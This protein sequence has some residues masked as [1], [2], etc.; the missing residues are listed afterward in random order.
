MSAVIQRVAAP[1]KPLAPKV[2]HEKEVCQEPCVSAVPVAKQMDLNHSMV[3]S[4]CQFLGFVRPV[5][6]PELRVVQYNS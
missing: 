2:L 1:S 3:Q 5:V 6:N 4:N